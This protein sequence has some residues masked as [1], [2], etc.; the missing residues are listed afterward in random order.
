MVHEELL[1]K[2]VIIPLMYLRYI[3]H[4]VLHIRLGTFV[5]TYDT[6][7]VEPTRA[8]HVHINYIHTYLS[9]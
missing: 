6:L 4:L 8:D 5:L 7:E 2:L 1:H 3:R 9:M